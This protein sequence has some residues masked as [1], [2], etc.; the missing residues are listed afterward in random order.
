MSGKY[1]SGNTL[2]GRQGIVIATATWSSFLGSFRVNFLPATPERRCCVSAGEDLSGSELQQ[3]QQQQQH[4]H[5]QKR[6]PNELLCAEGGVEE[7]ELE[8]NLDRFSSLNNVTAMGFGENGSDPHDV[9]GH[10][11]TMISSQ[12]NDGCFL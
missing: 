9:L 10:L 2:Y 7:V 8:S 12:H 5:R 11:P 1:Q 6:S 3:Q 4:S